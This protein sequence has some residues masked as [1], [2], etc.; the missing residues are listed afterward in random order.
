[1][2]GAPGAAADEASLFSGPGQRP[3]PSILYRRINPAPQLTNTGPWRAKPILISGASAYRDGEF[4]YQDFLYDDH[5]AK[6]ERG[7]GRSL[8]GGAGGTYSYPTASK[9]A[10]NAAD[11]VELRVKPLASATAFRLTF[12]TLA[13]PELTAATIAIGSSSSP[14]AFPHGANA[15][16]PAQL[17]LTWHGNTADLVDAASGDPVSTAVGVDVDRVRRQVQLT[18]P[19]SAFDP[20]RKTVRLA[21]AAGLWDRAN[22]RYLVPGAD[23]TATRPG[24]A[25]DAGRARPPSSTSPSARPSRRLPL[26]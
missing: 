10:N 16:A 20:G 13:K 7:E 14:R 15:S 24:G 3:G 9:Y 8:P 11:L 17:F 1:M 18:L 19:H 5:G 6:L 22:D 23:S 12:N 26:G 21:A 25:G 4:L 2:L